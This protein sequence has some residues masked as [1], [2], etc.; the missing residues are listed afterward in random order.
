VSS[1]APP[2]HLGPYRLLNVVHASKTVRLWHA[3]H[4]V[5]D[6]FFAVKALQDNACKDREEI[7]YL[8][9]E[10]EVGAKLDHPRVIRIQEFGTDQGI[11]YLAM[12][13]FA[14]PNMKQRIHQGVDGIAPLIPKIVLQA[15]EALA[16]FNNQGWVH[17]DIKPEN[18]LVGDEGDVKLIDYAL[19]QRQKRGLAR[20]LTPKS[21]VQGTPSY[22]S[23]EQIRGSA[24]D[25]R[26]DLYSLACT[27]YE[28]VTGKPPF[29]GASAN[30]LLTK[31]LKANPVSLEKVNAN[32]TPEFGEMIR[33]A[34]AKEPSG[35]QGSMQEFLHC[36]QAIRVFRRAPPAPQT[37]GRTTT[38]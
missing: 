12:E 33:R 7:G 36:L 25:D 38:P 24:L 35:R 22:I 23:P 26:A 15:T 3:Y 10:Y 32:V 2:S 29:T 18:F 34:M 31:H 30:E 20:L 17:R 16:Y 14:A 37:E 8:K 19:A 21:K 6:R 28:L 5:L 9:R 1:K 4:G 13:W 11:P 27:F